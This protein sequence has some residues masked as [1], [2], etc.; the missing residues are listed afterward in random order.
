M[1]P[2]TVYTI[3]T[4]MLPNA[5]QALPQGG[6]AVL[7]IVAKGETRLAKLSVVSADGKP[8]LNKEFAGIGTSLYA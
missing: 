8:L 3:A 2:T 6:Y 1:R 4:D 5:M 7:G